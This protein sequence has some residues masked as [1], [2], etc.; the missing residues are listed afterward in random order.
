MFCLILFEL[1][2]GFDLKAR[3]DLQW[4]LYSRSLHDP[5]TTD[6]RSPKVWHNEPFISAFWADADFAAECPAI[7]EY[8]TL[9]R[10]PDGKRRQRATL[11]VLVEDGVWKYCLNDRGQHRSCWA[12]GRTHEEARRALE[13]TLASGTPSWRHYEPWGRGK[14]KK[15]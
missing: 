8:L 7:W 1:V 14:H 11:T 3:Q 4:F 6:D 10:Y 9:D 13:A 15:S 2:L 12:T 5:R